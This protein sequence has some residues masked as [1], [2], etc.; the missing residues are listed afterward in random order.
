MTRS[1]TTACGLMFLLA[2]GVELIASDPVGTYAVVDRVVFEPDRA[3]AERVQLWGSFTQAKTPGGT[4]FPPERGFL[5]YSLPPGGE[6]AARA[7]WS[8]FDIHSGGDTVVAFGSRYEPLGRIRKGCEKAEEPDVYPINFGLTMINEPTRLLTTMDLLSLPRPISPLDGTKGLPPVKR[9]LR[10]ENVQFEMVADLKYHFEI[11]GGYGNTENEQ[12]PALDPGSN[13]PFPGE[14]S[15]TPSLLPRVGGMYRWR[16]WVSAG[17][18]TG[19]KAEACFD[20]GYIRGDV[21]GDAQVDISDPVSILMYLFLGGPAPEPL[22]VA[23]VND[24]SEIDVTDSIY[25]LNY[26]FLGGPAPVAFDILEE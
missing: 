5:Y 23:D 12:S 8:D 10:V 13:S 18:Y 21:T 15:W 24:S 6:K 26:E 14:T 11:E 17:D 7:E 3:A 19:P 22:A 9:D 16:S 1:I 4:Y 2:W 20:V 25:L